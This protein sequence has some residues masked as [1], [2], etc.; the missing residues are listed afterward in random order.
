MNSYIRGINLNFLP[1]CTVIMLVP[2]V[3]LSVD[4]LTTCDE[5]AFSYESG[6]DSQV[7]RINRELLTLIH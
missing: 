6:T 1:R 5:F 7:K 2:N 3:E 4:P